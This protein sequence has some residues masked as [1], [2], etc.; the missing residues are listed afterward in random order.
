MSARRSLDRRILALAL[1]AAGSILVQVIHRMVD[2]AW[3]RDLSTEAVAALTISTVSGWAFA[4]I[5]WCVAMGRSALIAPQLQSMPP[6]N[7]TWS[8]LV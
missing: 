7:Q 6:S 2:M 1:P 8:T 4:A 5:G 3:L